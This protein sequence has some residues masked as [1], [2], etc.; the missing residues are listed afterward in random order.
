MS[1]LMNSKQNG[2]LES[3]NCRRQGLVVRSRSLGYRSAPPP[4]LGHHGMS[5]FHHML[6]ATM[7]C[8]VTGLK[9]TRSSGHRLKPLKPWTKR[10]LFTF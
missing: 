7:C 10:N 2:L 8:F 5:F 1:P 3:G 9:A 6:P 4:P